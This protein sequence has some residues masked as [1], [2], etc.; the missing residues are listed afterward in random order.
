MDRDK[1][2]R[3]V[4][5]EIFTRVPGIIRLRGHQ[6]PYLDRDDCRTFATVIC[7]SP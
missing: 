7:Q 3:I 6:S 1:E 2:I 5:E 4:T